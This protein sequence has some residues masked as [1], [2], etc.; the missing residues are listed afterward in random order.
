M[1]SRYPRVSIGLPVYKGENFIRETIDSLLGQSFEDF[2]LVICDNASPDRTEE[3]CRTY[4]KQDKRV[5]Y[6]RNEKNIGAAQNCNRTFTLSSGQY[7]KWSAHDDICAPEYLAQCVAVLDRD[8]SVVLCHTKTRFINADGSLTEFD[9]ASKAFT[10]NSGA[11]WYLD[12]PRRLNSPK[13]H[14]R[15]NDFLLYTR[16]VF[17]IFGV[18]RREAL[19]NTEL[20]RNYYASDRALLADLI[21]RGRF[22]ELPDELFFRRCHPQQASQSSMKERAE[23]VDPDAPEAVMLSGRKNFFSYLALVRDAQISPIE[24]GLCFF[25][26]ARLVLQPNTLKKLFVP[27]QYNYFG[28]DFN[29]TDNQRSESKK[30]SA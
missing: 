1:S 19:E 24:K 4:A 5:R 18:I 15:L 20:F 29:R 22:F 2:E 17:E 27:G 6:F 16:I 26:L 28:I 7:F 30:R 12:P 25:A 11:H 3:I 10:D 21:L 14:E 23:R 13:P 9:P 8:P